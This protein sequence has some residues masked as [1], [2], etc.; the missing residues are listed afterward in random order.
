MGIWE[1]LSAHICYSLNNELPMS[2]TGVGRSSSVCTAT[3]EMTCKNGNSY[4]KHEGGNF[5]YL[6]PNQLIYRPQSKVGNCINIIDLF[7]EF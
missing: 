1:S 5:T 2:E 4:C 3:L 6:N 7:L